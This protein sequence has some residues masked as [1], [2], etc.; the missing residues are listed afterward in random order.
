MKLESLSLFNL[1]SKRMEWLGTRQ[2]VV[3]ENVANAN[4]PGYKARD[5]APFAEL[6]EAAQSGGGAMRT[7]EKHLSSSGAGNVRIEQ[8]ETSWSSKLDGN[9]VTLE[10]QTIRAA[11]VAENYKIAAK[12]YQKGYQLLSLSVTGRG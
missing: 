2:Q 8:D 12:L 9:T 10:Q 4:T 11:E 5:V 7:N 1:A 3:A 6:A